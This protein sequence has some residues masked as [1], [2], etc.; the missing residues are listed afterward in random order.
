MINSLYGHVVELMK[1]SVAADV[2]EMAYND[3]ANALQRSKMASEFYGAEFK[4]FKVRR[5]LNK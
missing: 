2:V 3:Y 1:H 5:S 4:L